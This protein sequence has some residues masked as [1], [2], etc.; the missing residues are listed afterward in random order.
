M[1]AIAHEMENG[2]SVKPIAG[3]IVFIG[4]S[5]YEENSV[6]RP[7]DKITG[8]FSMLRFYT[9]WHY[10]NIRTA[11]AVINAGV[12]GDNTAEML[13]RFDA[14]VIAH[15][16]ALVVIGGG[17]NDFNDLLSEAT[18]LVNKT[19]MFNRCAA[20]GA[21]MLVEKIGPWTDADNAT[22]DQ[23]DIWNADLAALVA[24]YPMATLV[25]P[26]PYCGQFRAGG[27]AGNLRDTKTEYYAGGPHM[28]MEGYWQKGRAIYDA[29]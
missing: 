17:V 5:L 15:T 21:Q 25:D 16:P 13:A 26:M 1:I 24:Q 28:T 7:E 12:A 27:P 3:T 14:D 6:P 19:E 20:I 23:I 18:Y 29:L 2:P 8:A 10:E 9:S 4:D 11:Y 22:W